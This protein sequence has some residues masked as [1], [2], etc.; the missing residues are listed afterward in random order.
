MDLHQAKGRL[1][2]YRVLHVLLQQVLQQLNPLAKDVDMQVDS[3][4]VNPYLA[5]L[6]YTSN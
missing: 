4:L 2:H 1:L 6:Y 5:K 3:T